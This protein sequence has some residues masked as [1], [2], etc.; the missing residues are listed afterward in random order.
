VDDL[1]FGIADALGTD[2]FFRKEQMTTQQ[3][4]YLGA[5]GRPVGSRDA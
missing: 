2:Y 3:L 4:D 1:K 5:P